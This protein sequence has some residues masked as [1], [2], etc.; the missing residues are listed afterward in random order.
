MEN[1]QFINLMDKLKRTFGERNYPDDRIRGLW[2]QFKHV[3]MFTFDNAVQ[4]MVLRER[5]APLFDQIREYVFRAEEKAKA[6]GRA[7]S[8]VKLAAC[9]ECNQNGWRWVYK[10]IKGR[11]YESIASCEN[12]EFGRSL[13]SKQS[14]PTLPLSRALANGYV[15][16]K[17]HNV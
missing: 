9:D 14:N 6:S 2:D 7:H 15:L 17:V 13:A 8:V 5:N 3:S 11:W 16:S 4:E 10:W 1:T 12:C